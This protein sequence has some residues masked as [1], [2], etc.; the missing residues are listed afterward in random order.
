MNLLEDRHNRARRSPDLPSFMRYAIVGRYCAFWKHED[1]AVVARRYPET[2]ICYGGSQR[3]RSTVVRLANRPKGLHAAQ[4]H[5]MAAQRRVSA[6]DSGVVGDPVTLRDPAMT[7]APSAPMARLGPPGSKR[8]PSL[9]ANV[10]RGAIWSFSSTI[11]LRLSSIGT[12]AIVARILS[13]HDFGVF[14]VATIAF[15]IVT[16]FGE[17]GVTSCLARADLDVDALAPTLWSV[18]LASSLIM[19]GVLYK[20]AGPIAAGLGS[21]DAARPVQVMGLVMVFWGL[22][23]VPAAQCVRDFR[24]GTLFRANVLSF[25][26]SMAVLLFLAKH[27]SGAMAFAWSRVA[28]QGVS[29]AVLLLSVPK[30]YL[31]GMTRGALRVLYKFGVPLA[32][33][34]FIGYILQNVDYALIGRL[35]GPVML[36]IYVLAFNVAT[37]SSTL[38]VGMLNTVSIPAFS[39]VKHD[40]A[41]L[42][43]AMADS[44][45][46]VMLIAAPMCTLVM[47]LSRPLVLTLYGGRWAAAAIVLSILACYGLIS[48]VGVLFSNMLAALGRS[49]LV[50]MVQLI[51]LAGLVPAMA[52]GVRKDGIVGAA[53]AH[54]VIIGPIV[55]PCYL[56]ALKRATGVRV[57][58]LAKAAFPPLAAAAAAAFLAW[59]TASAFKS[60][61]VQLA[62]G[63]AAGG[64]FYVVVTAPQLILL[65]MRGRTV[66]PRVRTV[67]RAFHIGGRALG[68]PAGPRPRHAVRKRCR[69]Y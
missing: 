6:L 65:V 53:I 54:I 35:I 11:L 48:V 46:V 14:A 25:V 37:W 60:P 38:L 36:G 23:A 20:F 69:M 1:A 26:P 13:P 27:G 21:R 9:S 57:G 61:L 2:C 45:R 43:G 4:V 16:A 64:S 39:R 10:R 41:K 51:W 42:R 32:C 17:F 7:A 66:H 8:P 49:K 47:V 59:L 19:A 22:S 15:T 29:C 33:A 55:L 63:L 44:V 31:P 56:I 34:N 12:T 30:L 50:L 24:Q 28:A 68:V 3:R 52:I 18:S 58:L 40:A 5:R 67:L 62:A